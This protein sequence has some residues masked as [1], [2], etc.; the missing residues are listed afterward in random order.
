VTEQGADEVAKRRVGETF[1]HV[2][3]GCQCGEKGHRPRISEAKSRCSE[4]VFV[5]RRQDHFF[6]CGHVRRR[7]RPLAE[8]GEEAAVYLLP[9]AHECVPVLRAE[10]LSDVKVAGVVD[11]GLDS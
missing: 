9:D 8:S 5:D 1:S 4:A 7:W 6:E 2:S 11:G 10:R 3:K